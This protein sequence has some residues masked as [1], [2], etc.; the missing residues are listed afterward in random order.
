MGLLDLLNPLNAITNAI[1]KW[2]EVKEN[3]KNDT[4]RIKAEVKISELEAKRD[5]QLASTIHDKWYGPRSLIGYIVVIF[6]AKLFVWDTV[7]GF[8]VTQYPGVLI[9]EITSTVIAFYFVTEGLRSVF[10]RSG[11]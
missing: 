8:G 7:L 1:I 4:E 9:M 11:K 6:L 3:A 2:Q 10:G 5:V